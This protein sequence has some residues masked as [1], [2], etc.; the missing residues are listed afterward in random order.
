VPD[1]RSK[2]VALMRAELAQ[3]A[4]AGFPRL[5]RIPQTD[6]IWFLDYF[7]GLSVADR[8]SLLD[9]LAVASAPSFF[10]QRAGAAQETHPAIARLRETRTRPGSK[11]GTRYT[12]VK[13]MSMDPSF[14]EPRGYHQT[15]QQNFTAL[16]FQPRADLLPDLSQ[17]K[18]A[19]A[20]L[21]RKL[22]NASMAR[23]FA[24][25]KENQPGGACNYVGHFNN[26]NLTVWVDFGS[27]LGQLRY[28]VSLR[29]AAYKLPVSRL[30]YERFWDAHLGWDYLT[31]EN[32][33]R[34]VDF[35]AEQVVYL[36]GVA[37]RLNG[38]E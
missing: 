19:K 5:S 27:M 15:W 6:I 10:P 37:E 28:G 16:N 36:A 7:G 14:R 8:E 26:S 18:A 31:D 20:P 29:N 17:L 35:F 21:V 33:P 4:A 12:S 13:M 34:S 24:A 11:G 2:V 22:V 3:E 38:L 30:S 32:A 9:A 23:L 1:L 25:N